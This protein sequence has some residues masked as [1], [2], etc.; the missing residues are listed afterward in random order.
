MG[1][2]NGNAFW[3]RDND[4]SAKMISLFNSYDGYYR[5]GA[6]TDNGGGYYAHSWLGTLVQDFYNPGTPHFGAGDSLITYSTAVSEAHLLHDGFLGEFRTSTPS[7][8]GAAVTD[9][10]QDG[11]WRRQDF[12]QGQCM[13]WQSTTGVVIGSMG[14]SPGPGYRPGS[15]L[16]SVVEDK[17]VHV[18]WPNGGELLSVGIP[19]TVRWTTA[20]SIDFVRVDLLQGR[21]IITPLAAK[22]PNGNTGGSLE[23]IPLPQFAGQNYTIGVSDYDDGNI[24]DV[25]DAEFSVVATGGVPGTGGAGDAGIAGFGG[26]TGGQIGRGG[27]SGSGGGVGGASGSGG[28]VGGASGSGG[29]VGGASGSGGGVGGA[30]GTGG[31]GGYTCAS[32][33]EVCGNHRD[34]D[35]NWEADETSVCGADPS[36]LL[37][38]R[39][40]PDTTYQCAAT[41]TVSARKTGTGPF[42]DYCTV[43]DT[44]AVSCPI[45]AASG[46]ES[47]EID[48][49]MTDPMN[50]KRRG[51]EP[52]GIGG[53]RFGTFHVSWDASD[54]VANI[55]M[56]SDTPNVSCDIRV[57][58]PAPAGQKVE[59]VDALPDIPADLAADAVTGT[60]G[61]G[62][63]SG[64]GG[65]VG[66]GGA[67]G[68]IG[69]GGMGGATGVG[70]TGGQGPLGGSVN[71]GGTQQGGGGVTIGGG[72]GSA[73][74]GAGGTV[75]VP[76]AGPD[77][78]GVDAPLSLPNLLRNPGFE[79]GTQY[80]DWWRPTSC[81]SGCAGTASDCTAL[82]SAEVAAGVGRDGTVAA[83]LLTTKTSNCTNC[84]LY[85]PAV[86]VTKGKSYQIRF[87]A[88]TADEV[89]LG[90]GLREHCGCPDLWG[91]TRP[92]CPPTSTCTDACCYE[93]YWSYE[94]SGGGT[95]STSCLFA[96]GDNAFIALITDGAWHQYTVTTSAIAIAGADLTRNDAKLSIA[97]SDTVGTVFLDDL[98]LNE[99]P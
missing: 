83:K 48:I 58:I 38:V 33:P 26:Q 27:S 64:T 59:P 81:I 42:T 66:T 17:R 9:E 11:V 68:D 74:G 60:G 78:A 91:A 54:M 3:M 45:S 22:Q 19:Y 51:C 2:Q 57:D 5:L 49:A 10:Y 31:G 77:S 13:L 90:I 93:A 82:C 14:A 7:V 97:F 67:G 4:V 95:C 99:L 69:S 36:S 52:F 92:S 50:G 43:S 39:W 55:Q 16:C 35:Q 46:G 73:S 98:E 24:Y 75:L 53:Q 30:S 18:D 41:I 80:W 25:S 70:G 37:I 32:T 87:W 88:M 96:S 15:F 47:W 21:T 61:I 62:N 76:D 84:F 89:A 29:G 8:Y 34:D 94:S 44:R 23:F 86:T 28:G 72:G 85:Q 20:G 12:E 79:S 65:I 63:T 56:V 1:S 40:S 71:T 6:P